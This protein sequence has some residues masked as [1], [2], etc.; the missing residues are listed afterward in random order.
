MERT[1]GRQAQRKILNCLFGIG[2]L[3]D[4]STLDPN[5]GDE[6]CRTLG[7]A[8]NP[9]AGLGLHGILGCKRQIRSQAQWKKLLKL[10]K[11]LGEFGNPCWLHDQSTLDRNQR[12]T[13]TRRNE[14]PYMVL[15]IPPLGL[16][17]Y[18]MCEGM[19]GECGKILGS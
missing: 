3:Y 2:N 18:D 6:N 15:R 7:Y 13:G 10:A 11:R 16:N 14:R 5:Q 19:G 1:C 12:P 4:E 8:E 17:V 9:C